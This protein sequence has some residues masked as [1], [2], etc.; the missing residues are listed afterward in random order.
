[1]HAPPCTHTT[2]Q[3]E[4]A[5]NALADELFGGP[6]VGRST[7]PLSVSSVGSKVRP[8]VHIMSGP[9]SPPQYIHQADFHI[10]SIT[11]RQKPAAGASLNLKSSSDFAALAKD[12]GPKFKKAAS[13]K[14][15]T[16]F[17]S[18]LLAKGAKEVLASDDINELVKCTSSRRS[19]GGR[20]N[21]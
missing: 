16:G 18:E 1:M 21:G 11:K 6:G 9:P 2:P 17:V 20:L 13:S 15:V 12:L 14:D 5:D 19:L 4:K 3:S 8:S 10:P 7:S